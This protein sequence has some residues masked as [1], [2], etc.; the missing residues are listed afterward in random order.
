MTNLAGPV[1]I[2][3]GRMRKAKRFRS[4]GFR[5]FRVCSNKAA[6]VRWNSTQ[7]QTIRE[8]HVVGTVKASVTCKDGKP[9]MHCQNKYNQP[10]SVSAIEAI[11]VRKAC[12]KRKT[13]I[14]RTTSDGR[15]DEAF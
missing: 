7:R 10:S 3:D 12:T 13:L 11:K 9:N 6:S 14:N 4:L 2:K 5:V 1:G 8:S 15:H